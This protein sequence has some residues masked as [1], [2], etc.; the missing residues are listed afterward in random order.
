MMGVILE[1]RK[2]GLHIALAGLLLLNA[3]VSLGERTAGDVILECESLNACG[4]SFSSSGSEE[5]GW[6]M[7]LHGYA[8]D[9]GSG[10]LELQ[11]GIWTEAEASLGATVFMFR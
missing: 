9:G 2:K 8:F 11:S 3:A 4:A 10:D 1:V 5:I 6:T 7:G